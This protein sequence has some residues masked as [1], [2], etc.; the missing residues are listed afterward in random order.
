MSK[1]SW[2]TRRCI[3]ASAP[4]P[5]H[6]LYM[7]SIVTHQIQG[8]RILH[9]N[10]HPAPRVGA[11][12]F[13]PCIHARCRIHRRRDIFMPV[14]AASVIEAKLVKKLTRARA[15]RTWL[16]CL[17]SVVGSACAHT[18]GTTASDL[19][20]FCAECD[21]LTDVLAAPAVT[22]RDWDLPQGVPSAREGAFGNE[23]S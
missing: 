22:R 21:F 19:L 9:L 4:H 20:C 5:N 15:A 23:M 1:F 12:R 7:S 17:D 16:L 10:K 11:P 14:R 13:A 2:S 3:D 8:L 6:D 18:A